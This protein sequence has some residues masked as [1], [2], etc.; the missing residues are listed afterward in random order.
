MGEP[1]R[2]VRPDWDT[3]FLRMAYLN[4]TRATCD[5]K[6]VGALIVTPDHRVAAAGY[7]GA[8]AGMDECNVIGHEL[9]EGHCVRT[10]HAESNALDY[11]GRLAQG[12]TL[13]VTV[14]PCYDCAKR[15]VN[16]GVH[17]VV[18]DEFYGSRYG[19]STQVPDFLISAGVEVLQFES[20][21]LTIFKQK[22]AEMENLEMEVLRQTVVEFAC[23]CQQPGDVAPVRCAEHGAPR[24]HD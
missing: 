21:G 5:R 4:A 18:Y 23:G 11:A 9:V 8:P 3:F 22:L 17:R 10:L 7:N 20:S 14:T 15:I 16:A 6:H 12:C 24:S 13:Y 1:H 19:K 2:S